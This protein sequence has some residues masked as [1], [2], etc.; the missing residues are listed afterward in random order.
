VN[1]TLDMGCIAD[2]E[3]EN[4]AAPYL[5]SLI[6][7]HERQVL[8]LRVVAIGASERHPDGMFAADFAEFAERLACLGLNGVEILEPVF[9]FG[10]TFDGWSLWPDAELEQ[11]EQRIHQAL[12][13]R[14]DFLWGQFLR[15]RG[16]DTARDVLHA[17]WR[18]ARCDVLTMW[19][20]L[21]YGGDI[22]VTR[23]EVYWQRDRRERLIR[24]GAGDVLTPQGALT[25]FGDHLYSL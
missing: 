8:T 23:N 21:R 19:A 7:L 22:F 14:I 11:L 13:P 16:G 5:R 4:T 3:E 15:R 1:L 20:H 18:Q 6:R 9:R 10:L 2:L 17:R 25:R 12:F 24:M